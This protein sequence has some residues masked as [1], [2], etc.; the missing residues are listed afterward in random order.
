MAAPAPLPYGIMA[1]PASVTSRRRP[2]PAS[3]RSCFRRAAQLPAEAMAARRIMRIAE[4]RAR[5][6]SALPRPHQRMGQWRV[7]QGFAPSTAGYGPLRDLPDWSFV[8]G[9]PAPLW[10]GQIR[11]LQENEAF[12][13]RAVQLSQSL[14]A[15][16]RPKP[17]PAAPS[18]RLRP[19]GSPAPPSKNQ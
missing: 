7:E 3:L 13:R 15:A 19:K 5:T 14:E 10:K 2:L 8:D 17:P 12:A 9:R 11:R 16:A 4:L 1:A 6:Q 18:T